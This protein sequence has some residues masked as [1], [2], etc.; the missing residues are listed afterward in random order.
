[1]D[2]FKK[3]V[4]VKA[5]FKKESKVL[6]KIKELK[7]YKF[8]KIDTWNKR[9]SNIE[10][11]ARKSL[12]KF[13]EVKKETHDIR[14]TWQTWGGGNMSKSLVNKVSRALSKLQESASNSL[15][16][17][18]ILQIRNLSN[19][20]DSELLDVL[21]KLVLNLWHTSDYFDKYNYSDS[22][23]NNDPLRLDNE[24]IKAVN[25]Y[26]KTY[27]NIREKKEIRETFKESRNMI[28]KNYH[29]KYEI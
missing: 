9:E 10:K 18:T 13:R 26:I 4:Q 5:N 16:K 7:K 28:F 29:L 25:N 11:N 19:Y 1:M 2:T 8:Q 27:C 3:P 6:N 21:N 15:K 12:N 22:Y 17:D 23:Y 24:K 14:K 20:R